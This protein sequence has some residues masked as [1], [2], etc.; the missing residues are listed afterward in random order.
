MGRLNSTTAT[1][2]VTVTP[3][4]DAPAADS[5]NVNT[6]ENTAKAITLTGSDV[7]NDP[8]TFAIVTAPNQRR[9]ERFQSEH[10]R[11]HLQSEREFQRR[12]Q[13]LPSG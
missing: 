9:V 5:Q 7:E 4:N 12:R 8:L 6:L 13:A 1:V 10:R 3:V 2:S 11:G